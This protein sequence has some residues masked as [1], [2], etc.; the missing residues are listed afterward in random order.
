M[1]KLFTEQLK[2][3]QAE[4]N[5]VKHGITDLHDELPDHAVSL[6]W[7]RGRERADQWA[8]RLGVEITDRIEQKLSAM[9]SNHVPSASAAATGSVSAPPSSSR[10]VFLSQFSIVAF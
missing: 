1:A 9:L 8:Q 2:G 7:S 6:D 4:V 10:Y 5:E 3:I